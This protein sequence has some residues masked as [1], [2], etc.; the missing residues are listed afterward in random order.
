MNGRDPRHGASRTAPWRTIGSIEPERAHSSHGQSAEPTGWRGRL[1]GRLVNQSSCT[2]NFFGPDYPSRLHPC[3]IH[4][5]QLSAGW[6]RGPERVARQRPLPGGFRKSRVGAARTV[7]DQN[8]TGLRRNDAG[9]VVLTE[10]ARLSNTTGNVAQGRNVE[11]NRSVDCLGT[12][13]RHY[14]V[15]DDKR[16]DWRDPDGASRFAAHEM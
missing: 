7:L 9:V 10:K 15:I 14:S 8:G 2:R 5:L 6:H 13:T 11:F 4:A 3:L 16:C 1:L 12:P